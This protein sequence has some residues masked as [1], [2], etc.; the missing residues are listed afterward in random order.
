[1]LVRLLAGE[2][3]CRN[4]RTA[5]TSRGRPSCLVAG[6]VGIV[7]FA[8]GLLTAGCMGG[9]PAANIPPAGIRLTDRA[10]A[11]NVLFIVID[12]MNDWVA[13][14]ND[15]R[16]GK[17]VIETPNLTALAAQGILFANAHT[18]APLC[19]PARASIVTGLY[20]RNGRATVDALQGRVFDSTVTITEHFRNHGY[21]TIGGGK[22]YPPIT[23]VA[24][25]WDEYLPFDRAVDE[26]RQGPA[27]NG[28]PLLEPDQFDW[29]PTDVPEERLVDARLAAWAVERL[30]TLDAEQPFFLGVGFHFPH[31]PWYLP[32]R[33]LHR[34][35]IETVPLPAA[36]EADLEDVPAEGRRLAWQAPRRKNVADYEHSD[37]HNV[38]ASGGWRNAVQAYMAAN[39]FIDSMLGLVLDGLRRSPHHDNTIVVVLSDNGWH[40][41]EK[42]HWRKATL[43]EE[44][45]RVPLVIRFPSQLPAGRV[46]HAPAS[47]V[48]LYPTLV[49]LAGL[50]SPPHALDGVALDDLA[51]GD[52][53]Q[54]LVLTAWDGGY[55]AVRDRHWR[56]IRYA[57]NAAELYDL[58]RDPMERTNLLAAPGARARYAQR[59][60]RYRAF[61][62]RYQPPA[63]RKV[64]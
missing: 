62:A 25:H 33:W 64:P 21:R 41:G 9:E 50:P 39:A 54:R 8:L 31:L 42:Q 43:W 44:S 47:L 5:A 18:P 28:I 40:L 2:T 36:D 19:V 49:R 29:G 58:R 15:G 30:Q 56:Y 59:L 6:P 1:M 37:H 53:P 3:G 10:S 52:F 14:L 26:K 32:P 22:L 24:R 7:A 35:P 55:L 27:M 38:L 45:T 60:S 63:D 20:P 57:A 23:D 16:R 34:S 51:R 61:M 4:R 48:D 17:P 46:V 13:P 12:D 11:P